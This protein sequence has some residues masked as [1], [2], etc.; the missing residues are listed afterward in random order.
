MNS[1]LAETISQGKLIHFEGTQKDITE[2]VECMGKDF[3][4]VENMGPVYER[5]TVKKYLE[6][7]AELLGGREFLH[8][9]V[10]QMH[11]TDF[12]D[13]KLKKCTKGQKRRVEIAREILKNAREYFLLN[14]LE[15]I[16]IDSRKIILV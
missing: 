4:I 14:P 11:L 7:F 9:A 16:D 6:F 15:D 12:L 3:A 5:M 2:I 10:E 8:S 1:Q 13:K